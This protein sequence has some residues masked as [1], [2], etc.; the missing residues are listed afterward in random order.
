[1][2][3]RTGLALAAATAALGASLTVV[4]A[5][6][7]AATTHTQTV[8]CSASGD[9]GWLRTYYTGSWTHGTVVRMYYKIKLK[10]GKKTVHND[11]MVHDYAATP[12]RKTYNHDDGV[13]DGHWHKIR[14]KN[15][16]HSDSDPLTAY[17]EFDHTGENDPY[18][19]NR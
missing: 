10:S 2:S 3:L 7:G 16:R 4:A 8:G 18:C 13:A 14:E 9:K 17:F 5:P 19:D 6:A 11:I 15:Y 12:E 1:M